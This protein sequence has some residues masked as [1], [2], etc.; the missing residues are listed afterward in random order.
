MTYYKSLKEGKW[1]EIDF[2]EQMANI[3]IEVLRGMRWK[4]KNE[5]YFNV[6]I[7]KAI[8]LI[9][10]T[11]MDQKN[12]KRLKEICRLKEVLIDY[13]Y[14]NNEFKSSDKLW[15]NYFNPFI[16]YAGKIREKRRL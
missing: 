8:E 1:F 9:D 16:Y 3:G 2:I 12:K 4:N 6:S 13:F 10:L 7:E 5:K 14:G 15:E 11:K